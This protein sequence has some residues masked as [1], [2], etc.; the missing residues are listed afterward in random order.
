MAQAQ[1]KQGNPIMA[2]HTP[3]TAVAAGAVVVVG[4]T[5]RVAHRD[6]AANEKGA[7]AVFG[8]IY[9]MVGAGVYADG[10]KVYWDNVAG[11]VTTTAGSLKVFGELVSACSADGAT[12][13]V[14]H[15]PGTL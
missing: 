12:C 1:F 10:T 3:G 15:N 2:D 8:G 14:F 7:L 5:P 9:E 11:K 6:I 4:A 13:R